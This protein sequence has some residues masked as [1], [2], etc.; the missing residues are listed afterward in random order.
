MWDIIGAVRAVAELGNK[1]VPLV[2]GIFNSIAV[3]W[4]RHGAAKR[5]EAAKVETTA[6]IKTATTGS[7]EDVNA[8]YGFGT[9]KKDDKK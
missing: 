7:A 6:L 2:T 1:V 3:S 8:A 4:R 5:V 9:P